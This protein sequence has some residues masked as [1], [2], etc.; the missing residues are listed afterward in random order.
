MTVVSIRDEE[1]ALGPRSLLP[2]YIFSPPTVQQLIDSSEQALRSKPCMTNEEF[3]FF[4]LKLASFFQTTPTR[5][6]SL[7]SSCVVDTL[8]SALISNV[9]QVL[10]QKKCFSHER[11][12]SLSLLLCSYLVAYE[13][14]TD[15]IID[16]VNSVVVKYILDLKDETLH[17][18]L[19][20]LVDALLEKNKEEYPIWF[21]WVLSLYAIHRYSALTQFTTR[22]AYSDGLLRHI[23]ELLDACVAYR[24]DDDDSDVH[25]SLHIITGVMVSVKC[26]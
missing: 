16:V 7:L 10:R 9:L 20:Q 13:T 2:D 18:C 5:L 14:Y 17:Q 26:S 8:L 24:C 22:V 1:D 25:Y 12:A 19:V 3:T 4:L 21:D 23:K 6:R 15:S 11:N